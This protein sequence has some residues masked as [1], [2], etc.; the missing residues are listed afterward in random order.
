MS[1]KSAEQV[2]SEW[3]IDTKTPKDAWQTMTYEQ[4]AEATGIS[5]GYINRVLIK[6]AAQTL[7]LEYQEAK[8]MRINARSGEK[9]VAISTELVDKI[10]ALLTEKDRATV[11]AELGLS[12]STVSRYDKKTKKNK[13]SKTTKRGKQ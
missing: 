10:N 7:K 9:G 12:Y 13:K 6:V 8:E 5:K 4:I 3:I 2:I 1:N 11:A